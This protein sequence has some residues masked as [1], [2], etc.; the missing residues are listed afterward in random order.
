[1][2]SGIYCIGPSAYGSTARDLFNT[3]QTHQLKLWLTA[4]RRP[5]CSIHRAVNS[6]F[7]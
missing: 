4:V 7:N 6:Y 1:M 5:L 2:G 3:N